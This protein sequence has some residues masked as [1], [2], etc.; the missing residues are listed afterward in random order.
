[1]YFT[2]RC[3]SKGCLGNSSILFCFLI[4]NK[5]G[6][7]TYK[8]VFSRDLEASHTQIIVYIVTLQRVSFF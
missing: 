5:V 3:S 8:H 2:R 6:F 4:E 7:H 1:M